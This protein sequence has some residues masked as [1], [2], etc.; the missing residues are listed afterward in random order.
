MMGG[1][2]EAQSTE[3]VGSRFS[4]TLPC[5][6]APAAS[7]AP[8][9]EPAEISD[10][11][12]QLIL[13]ILL[14]ED[15][16]AN[17]RIVEHF[18]RPIGATLVIVGDGQA[19]I[20]ALAEAEFDVVLMD[21]QMP[22][23]DGLEATRRIRA[24]PGPNRDVPILALTANVLDAQKQACIAAGMSGHVAKPIDARALLGAVLNLGLA[25]RARSTSVA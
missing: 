19:A 21:V 10:E 5:A 24:E 8:V 17:Q 14:A 6:L 16:P 25:R 18:L 7:A 20:N 23:L 2:I 15:N 11:G 3:G 1:R 9:A 4:L 12:P 22:V 13:R